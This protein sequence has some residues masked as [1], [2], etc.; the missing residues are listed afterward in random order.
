MWKNGRRIT[1]K[2]LDTRGFEEYGGRDH[3]RHWKTAGAGTLCET[4]HLSKGMFNLYRGERE[5]FSK[6][7]QEQKMVDTA[8]KQCQDR[9]FHIVPF[10]TI[11]M[12]IV[13]LIGRGV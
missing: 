1:L 12:L 10:H 11:S 5:P 9:E 8:I 4:Q 7:G 3:L 2:G 6:R 13:Y